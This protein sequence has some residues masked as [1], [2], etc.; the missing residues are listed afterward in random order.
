MPTAKTT[1]DASVVAQMLKDAQNVKV[2]TRPAEPEPI[3][4]DVKDFELEVDRKSFKELFGLKRRKAMR[5]HNVRVFKPEDWAEEMRIMIPVIDTNYVFQP[6]QIEKFV[7]A[8][9]HGDT[10]L[11]SGPTGSGKSTMVEQYCA[12]TGRPFIRI[13]MTGDMESSAFFGSMIVKD[14]ATI[15]V[16]G[17]ITDAVKLGA[18]ALVDEWEVSPPEINLGLQRLLEPSRVLLLKDKPAKS[19]DKQYTGVPEFRLVCGGNTLGSG[20]IS[21]EYAGTQVQNVATV[22]RFETTIKLGYLDKKHETAIIS[23]AVPDLP[24]EAIERML[25]FTALIRTAKDQGSVSMGMSPRT[26]INWAKK[27]MY[28]GDATVALTIAF[29]DKIDD[30]EKGEVIKLVKKVYGSL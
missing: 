3:K 2:S 4:V 24:K 7:V 29:L 22:D 28:W 19:G 8:M 16:D 5:D 1:V 26:L 10:C 11:I 13:N 23:K 21:G 27:T 18:V 25:Q 9:E 6:D 14:G 20:D 15:W 17:P 30:S 12:V